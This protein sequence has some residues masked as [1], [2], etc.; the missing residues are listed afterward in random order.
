MGPPQVHFSQWPW[1]G[2]GG[3]LAPGVPGSV[4]G[5]SPPPPG[6]PFPTLLAGAPL[7]LVRPGPANPWLWG[8]HPETHGPGGAGG[9][10]LAPNKG[11]GE[12][13]LGLPVPGWGW[14]QWGGGQRCVSGTLIVCSP[15]V[16]P[17]AMSWC[18]CAHVPV[19]RSLCP[20]VSLCLG[21]ICVLMSPSAPAHGSLPT[22]TPAPCSR[23]CHRVLKCTWGLCSWAHVPVCV[24][25]GAPAHVPGS[26]SLPTLTC[27]GSPR[28]GSCRDGAVGPCQRLPLC[29]SFPV[30]R[31]PMVGSSPLQPPHPGDTAAHPK[32]PGEGGVTA[33]RRAREAAAS[34]SSSPPGA[35]ISPGVP[36]ETPLVLPAIQR[37]EALPGGAWGVPVPA[38]V[39]LPIPPPIPPRRDPPLKWTL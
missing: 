29:L 7:S 25:P 28:P 1:V 2:W 35:A 10:L 37:G 3:H 36:R 32:L 15:A 33:G 19:F 9:L 39:C 26:L 6:V 17:W 27:C 4:F 11:P 18:P 12:S 31:A 38:G 5:G 22:G 34:L 14:G 8:G 24:S 13:G 21:C 16:C 23:L 20:E 30:Y